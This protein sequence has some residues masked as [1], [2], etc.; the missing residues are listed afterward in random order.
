MEVMLKHI[1]EPSPDIYQR[2]QVQVPQGIQ[3]AIDKLLANDRFADVVRALQ[4][5][6]VTRC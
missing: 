4:T 6:W 5:D 1:N 2:T 3:D